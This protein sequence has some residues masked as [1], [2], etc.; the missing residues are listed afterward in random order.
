LEVK[1]RSLRGTRVI[2]VAGDVDLSSVADVQA[3]I[4][5]AFADSEPFFVLDL[6]RVGFLD[7]S[8]LHTLFRTLRRARQAGGDIA[9]VCVDPTVCRVLEVFGLAGE[10]QICSDAEQAAAA[11]ARG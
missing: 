10:I 11:L 3:H 8:V 5:A 7:S 9:I 6:A 1:A 4:D 2:A